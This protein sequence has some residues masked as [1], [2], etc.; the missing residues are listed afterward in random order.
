MTLC[1]YCGCELKELPKEGL[2]Y[3]DLPKNA[4]IMYCEVCG[5]RFIVENGKI[6]DELEDDDECCILCRHSD[7]DGKFCYLHKKEIDPYE[8]CPD[9]EFNR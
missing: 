1:K 8:W 2:I 4:T 3:K 6:V 7:R 5:A 9:F